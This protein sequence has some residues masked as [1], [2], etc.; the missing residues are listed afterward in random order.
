M[1]KN[2]D[3]IAE[4]LLSTQKYQKQTSIDMYYKDRPAVLES[5][6]KARVENKLSFRDIAV[7]LSRPD[8]FSI[9]PGSVKLW[10]QKRGIE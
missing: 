9:S 10:L 4:E 2:S 1:P 3:P 8:D 5:I 6:V 7:I